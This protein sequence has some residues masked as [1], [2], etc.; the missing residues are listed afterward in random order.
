MTIPPVDNKEALYDIFTGEGRGPQCQSVIHPL[1]I[2]WRTREEDRDGRRWQGS[3][4][5]ACKC[6]AQ[7]VFTGACC[8]DIRCRFFGLLSSTLLL[9]IL[10]D[11][12]Y[13][14]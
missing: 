10:G 2:V 3:P 13:F 4:L 7:E 8:L 6:S 12:F 14:I 5:V 1:P 11:V 9:F